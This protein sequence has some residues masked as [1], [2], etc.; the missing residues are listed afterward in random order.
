MD[1]NQQQQP[2]R[3]ALVRQIEDSKRAVESL[4]HAIVA[5]LALRNACQAQILLGNPNAQNARDVLQASIRPSQNLLAEKRLALA[6]LQV[7]LN[8]SAYSHHFS[9]LTHFFPFLHRTWIRMPETMPTGNDSAAG[10]DWTPVAL[11]NLK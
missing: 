7:Q 10:V 3:A 5:S 11:N 4:E 9:L 1:S 6:A 8:V 2:P